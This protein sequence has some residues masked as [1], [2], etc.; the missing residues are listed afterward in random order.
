MNILIIN[1]TNYKKNT[2]YIAKQVVNKISNGN[3][4]VEEIT[5]PKDLPDFCAGC[6]ACYKEN[7]DLCPHRSFSKP[8]QE[9]MDAAD[10]LIFVVPTYVYHAPSSMINFLDHFCSLWLLHKPMPSMFLK[11]AV[12]I[13]TA[14]GKGQKEA[15]KDIT[16]SLEYWGVPRIYTLGVSLK[17]SRIEKANPKLL[18]S[19]YK[20]TSKIAKKVNKRYTCVTPSFKARYR[21][22][23]IRALI[24]HVNMSESDTKYWKEQGWYYKRRPW[25]KRKF[26]KTTP[27]TNY[28]KYK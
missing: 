14:A 23:V 24:K 15:M 9:K 1:G 2:Y 11:Q 4:K 17:A 6:G 21:F 3:T 28:K 19:I 16:D 13:S 27:P 20:S 22:A 18:R 8:L 25:V 10:V 5:L 26:L 12:V 7:I